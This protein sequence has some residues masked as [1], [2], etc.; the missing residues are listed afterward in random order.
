MGRSPGS[1]PPGRQLFLTLL[2]SDVGL[3]AGACPS[4]T[5]GIYLGVN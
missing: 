1:V 2:L 3:R 4:P 5:Q